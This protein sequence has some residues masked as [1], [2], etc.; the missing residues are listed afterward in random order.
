MKVGDKLLKDKVVV[1]NGLNEIVYDDD[2][3]Y[4]DSLGEAT[5]WEDDNPEENKRT[6]PPAKQRKIDNDCKQ[7]TVDYTKEELQKIWKHF[8]QREQTS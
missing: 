1:D 2:I 7:I 6:K 4:N 5:E 8:Y 3:K